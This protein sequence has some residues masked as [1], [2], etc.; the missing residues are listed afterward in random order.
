[1]DEAVDEIARFYRNYHS[2]RYVGER[3]VMRLN[4]PVTSKMLIRLNNEFSDLL[5]EGKFDVC[6]SLPAE[7]DEVH[8]KDM[9]RLICHKKRGI[10]GRF[11]QLIDV[12]NEY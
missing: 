9:P 3:L 7:S 2:Y 8:L 6:E 10:A 12:V 1:M 11:R 5:E 4:H